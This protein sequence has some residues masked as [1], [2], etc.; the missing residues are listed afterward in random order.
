ME[1]PGP[2]HGGPF[3]IF[4]KTQLLV[5]LLVISQCPSEAEMNTENKNGLFYQP[6]FRQ[7]HGGGSDRTASPFSSLLPSRLES[8][9]TSLEMAVAC[10]ILRQ[11]VGAD[12]S[13]SRPPAEFSSRTP[14]AE[15]KVFKQEP[16]KFTENNTFLHPSVIEEFCFFCCGLNFLF[17]F[18]AL[19]PF[20]L[21]EHT[22]RNRH[23]QSH[24]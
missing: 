20:N 11:P 3:L 7:P 8:P 14:R 24:Y 10:V 2:G 12:T 16:T 1:C 4:S 17:K 13:G 21:W 5:S 18:T 23:H 9:G 19:Y 6:F 15:R 22:K